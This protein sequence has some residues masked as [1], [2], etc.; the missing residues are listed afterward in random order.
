M[1][2]LPAKNY[3]LTIQMSLISRMR[4]H[5]KITSTH[6]YIQ[7]QILHNTDFLLQLLPYRLRQIYYYARTPLCEKEK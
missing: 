1:Y 2:G 7:L 5:I 4:C 3:S 6:M